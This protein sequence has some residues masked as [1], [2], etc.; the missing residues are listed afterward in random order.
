MKQETDDGSRRLVVGRARHR[1]GLARQRAARAGRGL[2]GV[3]V[4]RAL[5]RLLPVLLVRERE[6]AR[7]R[8]N[9]EERGRRE[10]E[11]DVR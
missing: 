5:G 6:K 11:R 9:R 1:G 4:G 2:C 10:G 7:E 8:E 3:A